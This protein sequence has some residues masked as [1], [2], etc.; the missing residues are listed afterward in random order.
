MMIQSA[1]RVVYQYEPTGWSREGFLKLGGFTVV[2]LNY[3]KMSMIRRS[4]DSVLAQDYPMLDILLMDDASTDGSGEVMESLARQYCG[5]HR[6]RVV[7]NDENQYI[8]GQWNIAAKLAEGNWLG[9]FCGDDVA[10]PNRVSLAAERILKMPTL[11]GFSTASVDIDG[12]T[13]TVLPDSHYVPKPYVAHGK[14]GAEDLVRHFASNGAT[15]FWH[16]SLFEDPLP[17][18]SLDDD[19]LHMRAYVLNAGVEGPIFFYDSSI[20]TIDYTI[21][22]GISS[23]GGKFERSDSSWTKTWRQNVLRQKHLS[24]ISAKTLG[25]ALDYARSK[26][27]GYS[28]VRAFSAAVLQRR[29]KAGNT[30]SRLGLMPRLFYCVLRCDLSRQFKVQLLRR[31]AHDFCLELLGLRVASWLSWLK[32]R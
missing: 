7:R 5:R 10:H 16:I 28:F 30:F 18:V 8:T 21:G 4:V 22:V 29:L 26:G 23:G 31:F 1:G 11:R 13:G 27:V 32:H 15:S 24:D 6:V 3:N 14:D 19:Y 25:R 2:F 9:M 17:R 12:R 20:Q